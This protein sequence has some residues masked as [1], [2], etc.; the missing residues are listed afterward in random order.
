MNKLMSAIITGSVIGATASM[1]AVTNMHP[2]DRKRMIKR[3]R[4]AM[5][6]MMDNLGVY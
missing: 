6:N 3:N 4:R 5:S 1:I 2:K